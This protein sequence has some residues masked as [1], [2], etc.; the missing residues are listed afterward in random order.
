M[1]RVSR[2]RSSY[3][4]PNPQ[5]MACWDLIDDDQKFQMRSPSGALGEAAIITQHQEAEIR[6]I[7]QTPTTEYAGRY[8]YRFEEMWPSFVGQDQTL[9]EKITQED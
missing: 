4:T 2:E 7:M 1:G 6:R 8:I 9:F 5:L 3:I